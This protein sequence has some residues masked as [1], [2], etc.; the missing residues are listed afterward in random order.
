M[1]LLL[2][3]AAAIWVSGTVIDAESGRPIRDAFVQAISPAQHVYTTESGAF[4]FRVNGPGPF[5]IRVEAIGYAM[6]VDTVVV[7]GLGTWTVRIAL[8][9][10]AMALPPLLVQAEE[11]G[12]GTLGSTVLQRHE[13]QTLPSVG[14]AD[15]LRALSILPSV[16]N[17]SDF[18]AVPYLRGASPAYSSLTLD[19]A[20]LFNPYH[21]GGFF[22]AV[23]QEAV[24]RVTVSPAATPRRV[25]SRLGGLIEIEGRSPSL[26]P[27][28]TLTAGLTSAAVTA[29]GRVGETV[30]GVVAVRRTYIDGL[31]RVL[32]ETGLVGSRVPYHF[33][34]VYARGVWDPTPGHRL[35]LS[36][37]STGEGAHSAPG[38]FFASTSE[39]DLDWSTSVVAAR[40][41]G[42]FRRVPVVVSS[43]YSSFDLNLSGFAR[44]GDQLALDARSRQEN[45]RVAVEGRG[46]VGAVSLTA[47]VEHTDYRLRH[48]IDNPGEFL[49]TVLPG[50]ETD[51]D[52]T[53][54][55]AFVEASTRRGPFEA[56]AG[57][58]VEKWENHAAA[59]LPR[60]SGRWIA[61]QT[62]SLG[63]SWSRSTQALVSLRNE[64]SPYSAMLGLDLLRG[65]SPGEALPVGHDL[66]LSALWEPNASV[67]FR[68]D[69][70]TREMTGVSAVA[71]MYRG[72]DT[73]LIV[74]DSVIDLRAIT[75]GVDAGV[76][77][78]IGSFA[79][80]TNVGYELNEWTI[81]GWGT[82]TPRYS[83][84]WRFNLFAVR[85]IGRSS[86]IGLRILAGTGQPYTPLQG[87][88]PTMVPAGDS[89]EAAP[90]LPVLGEL[91]SRTLRP[92]LRLDLHWERDWAV[93]LRS[94]ESELTLFV[95]L[96]NA[97]NRKNRLFAVP[98]YGPQGTVLKEPVQLPMLPTIGVRWRL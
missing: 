70:F 11:R 43:S 81:P 49:P 82:F 51:G 41:S 66:L 68:L 25:E 92:Y 52:I 53:G 9:P 24:D 19:G 79:Y 17:A 29:E 32:N 18:S 23:P 84:R 87:V 27:S 38:G 42:G 83:R 54:D 36:F 37:Y 45:V 21:F 75:R 98:E 76:Q 61:G 67:G 88:V 47:G 34:D 90:S 59:W 3:S 50:M 10:T 85:E 94:R 69:A 77:G 1:W 57:V 72:E 13:L 73:P 28:V 14:E 71:P 22:S 96:V 93:R 91:N 64:E 33:L 89:A 46:G 44:G 16:S 5:V 2:Q 8:A 63:A 30:G 80:I 97:L 40:Y 39:W 48:I 15:V 6:I 4:R 86:A 20:H 78:V 7:T 95:Q 35:A 31:T 56:S 65:I 62:W 55:F 58:R 60:V 26:E 74:A 12:A